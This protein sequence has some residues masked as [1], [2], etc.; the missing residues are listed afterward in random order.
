MHPLDGVGV[1]VGRGHLDRG[2]QVD[3]ERVLRRGL[4]DVG[5]LVTDPLGELQLGARVG[6]RGVF[7][8]DLRVADVLGVLLAEPGRRRGDVGDAVHVQAEHDTTLQ[9]GRGVVEVDD[10]LLGADQ[11][12][13]GAR[14]EVLAGLRQDLD[15]D[16]AGDAV[17]LDQS[18]DEVEVRLARGG[19]ADLDLLVAEPDEQV[20]HPHLALDVH[21]VDERLVAVPQIHRAPARGGLDTP[22]GPGAVRE[23]DPELLVEGHVPRERHAGGLL[24]V[25]RGGHRRSSGLGLAWW[26]A[27]QNLRAGAAD[28]SV[29]PGAA[30]KEEAHPHLAN[31]TRVPGRSVG[32]RCSLVHY[33]P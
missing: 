5:D 9:R 29:G 26:P 27:G 17:R 12:L 31:R 14:D 3:D 25:D 32:C 7:E 15:G 30:T 13:V 23:L 10:G 24:R 19:E 16:V 20:E 11:R 2:R 6:L 33:R 22:V 4:Q 8:P 18:T 21:R 28:L 1:D